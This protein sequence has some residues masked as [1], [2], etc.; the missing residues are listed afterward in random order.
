MDNIVKTQEVKKFS[1]VDLDGVSTD[2]NLKKRTN[3]IHLCVCIVG[4]LAFWFSPLE[5]ISKTTP[6]AL[7]LAFVVIY[8]WVSLLIDLFATCLILAGGGL[9]LGLFATKDIYASFPSSF[10]PFMGICAVAVGATNTLLTT[11][12][13]YW[14]LWKFGKSPRMI[15]Y[16]ALFVSLTISTAVSNTAT[17]LLVGSIFY[18]VI[19]NIG[20]REHLGRATMICIALGAGIGGCGFISGTSANILAINTWN[21]ATKGAYTIT[22]G[23]WAPCGLLCAYIVG[24]IACLMYPRWFKVPKKNENVD[25][26]FFHNKLKEIGPVTG[27]EV[28]WFILIASMIALLIMGFDLGTISLIWAM[29]CI[30]PGFGIMSGNKMLKS[31][32]WFLLFII[33]LSPLMAILLGPVANYFVKPMSA[34]LSVMGVFGIMLIFSVAKSLIDCIFVG[35]GHGAL[36]LMITIFSPIFMKM[37]LNPVVMLMPALMHSGTAFVFGASGNFPCVYQYGYWTMTDTIKPGLIMMVIVPII[38]TIVCYLTLPMV[39]LGYYI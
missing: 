34:F 7:A 17:A 5:F 26:D 38:T 32:P 12:F 14:C 8:L 36:V 9:L 1:F 6:K 19:E 21:T 29:I 2:V 28:R 33:S 35:A 39:G 20:E 25:L 22:F 11:R 37:G 15:C 16:I 24:I 10:L 3:L 30:M 23:Q 27:A 4:F 18:P 31:L 13:A